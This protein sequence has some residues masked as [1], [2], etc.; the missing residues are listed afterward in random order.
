VK[1]P[2]S[3]ELAGGWSIGGMQSVFWYTDAG[4]RNRTW[5]PTFYLERELTKRSDAFLE[6]AGD[7]AQRGGS[8]QIAHCGAAYRI[9]PHQQVDFHFGFGLTHDA[10]SRF[11]AV[12]YSIRIDRGWNR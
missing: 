12:G 7:F 5:E 11:I 2:W 1:F 6:Y 3:K 4:R 10:P 9:R 8:R